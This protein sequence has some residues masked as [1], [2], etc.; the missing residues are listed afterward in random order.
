MSPDFR[1]FLL[2][3]GLLH[4]LIGGLAWGIWA[5]SWQG[6]VWQPSRKIR[7]QLR[8]QPALRGLPGPPSPSFSHPISTPE[9]PPP[10]APPA[11][12]SEASLR[13]VEPFKERAKVRAVIRGQPSYPVRPG[14]ARRAGPPRPTP[15]AAWRERG[16]QGLAD[17]E[18][19]VLLKGPSYIPLPDFLQGRDGHFLM[20][21]RCRIEIDGSSR[22]EVM[23]SCGAPDL[24]E[25]VRQSFSGLPWY[26]GQLAGRPLALT[27]RLVIEGQWQAGERSIDWGGRI[28]GQTTYLPQASGVGAPESGRY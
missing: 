27:V 15:E 1:H 4:T 18:G 7:L 3:S 11:A 5:P 2:L 20:T 24:D 8:P 23:E 19:P 25:A 22:I 13:G 14:V 26:R 16:E 10:S 9:A 21:L 12:A 17:L 6:P 28:P